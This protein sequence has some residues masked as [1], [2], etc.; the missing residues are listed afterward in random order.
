[1]EVLFIM[2]RLR[3]MMVEK[4]LITS[5]LYVVLMTGFAALI[6][7]IMLIVMD[8]RYSKALVDNGFIQGDLGEYNSYLNKSG[9]L[10][11]DIIMLNDAAVV[12]ETEISL[13]E[14][15]EKVDYYL[16]QF[17]EKLESAKE[18]ELL[19]DINENY[20]K[21]IA[22]RDK[23]IALA[24]SGS[25]EE[26]LSSFRK[27]AIPYLENVMADSEELLSMNIEMG[28]EK[29]THL[30]IMSVI[31]IVVVL[32][33]VVVA[34]VISVMLARATAKDFG[35]PVE[36]VE[37]ALEKLYNGELDIIIEDD[38]NNEFGSMAT[39]L[40][41]AVAKIKTYVDTI[42]FGLKEVGRGNF[43]VQPPIE[44]H[45]DF[46][47]LK[48][49]IIKITTELSATMR[50]I[51]EGADQTA[52]GAEQM[53][54]SAQALAEGATSQA[55]AAEEL[56]ATIENVAEAAEY[57]AQKAGEAHE[58]AQKFANV[59][60]ESGKEMEELVDAMAKITETSKEIENIIGE[61]EDIA[62]QTNLL[63]LNASIEAA[64]AGEAGRGF[65]VV[66]DQIGKL[67][68]DS[69]RSAVHTRELISKCLEEINK[70]DEIAGKTAEALQQVVEGIQMLAAA[71][72]E[73]SKLSAEQADT[74]DQIHKGIEQITEVI[75]NNSAA[76][77]ETSA[78]SEE[79]AAQSQTL[80]MLIEKFQLLDE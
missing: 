58:V 77:E 60:E 75:Q 74:I 43:A 56:T 24:K 63:S 25:H 57:S 33:L 65:A 50:S 38:S 70:G 32:I 27:D 66:A 10:A 44:F 30:T 9:A 59:A 51:N 40:N 68:A 69:A 1:M 55:G 18:E 49:S 48:N 62:S 14:S 7:I 78:T 80:K 61:I 20:P 11:R 76:A 46:V 41:E 34:V 6:S 28:D 17:T 19:E 23:A 29:S 52:I 42:E 67:A 13:K 22:A 4:R 73:S 71:S 12:A 15:D 47:A 31:V 36:K 2:K 8:S 21:Y 72:K 3:N 26:A 45:G 35:E 16:Q 39:H 54:D 5:F 64:R 79:L 53:A 37:A